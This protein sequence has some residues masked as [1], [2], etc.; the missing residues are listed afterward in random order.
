MKIILI[1]LTLIWLVIG[2]YN[3]KKQ[4][5]SV[6]WTEEEITLSNERVLSVN[7]FPDE[8]KVSEDASFGS[9]DR[10]K[11]VS[12]SPDGNWLAIA[13]GGVAHDFGWI[14]NV[15]AQEL[16]PVVFSYG[17]GVDIKGWNNEKDVTFIVTTPMPATM[18][19][20]VD[21]INLPEYPF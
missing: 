6:S 21:V 16:T 14:Y 17:G 18:E 7:D 4:P 9:S 12:M 10:I 1:I 15:N 20:T 8:V 3:L 11:K 2:A 13:I 5:Q 19:K